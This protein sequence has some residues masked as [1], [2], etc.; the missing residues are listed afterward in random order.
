MPPLCF[1]SIRM[2]WLIV[3]VLALVWF[4]LS[5]LRGENLHYLD[6]PPQPSP[7]T[8]PS[9][10]HRDVV[11]TA[12]GVCQYRQNRVRVQSDQDDS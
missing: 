4:S 12:A 1:G 6:R 8:P 2:I 9:E 5:Y 7:Q 10:A 11:Q 3:I